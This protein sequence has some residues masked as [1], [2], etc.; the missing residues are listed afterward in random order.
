MVNTPD[1]DRAVRLWRD[2]LGVRLALDREFAQRGLRMLFFRSAGVTLEYVSLLGGK[3]EGDDALDGIAY[4]VADLASVRA[5]LLAEGLDVSEVRTGNK[6]GTQVATV[7]SGTE[8]VPTLLIEAVT[9]GA[10]VRS[11]R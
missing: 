7:R 10:V 4:R 9:P 11:A 5:R 2:G 3:G 6:Q 8:G 1:P